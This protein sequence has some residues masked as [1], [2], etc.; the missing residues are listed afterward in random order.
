MPVFQRYNARLSYP[1]ALRSRFF[2][3]GV[4]YDPVFDRV[5]I[6]KNAEKTPDGG[7]MVDV[8][9]PPRIIRLDLGHYEVEWVPLHEPGFSPAVSPEQ[10]GPGSPDQNPES[11]TAITA[12]SLYYDKWFYRPVPGAA[13]VC[14]LGLQF[15]LYPD[16]LF[17]DQDYGA[18]RYELKQD[19]KIIVRGEN[20]DVRL[21]IIPFP[22]YRDTR[23]PIVDYLLPI[24][25]M[26]VR[27]VDDQN[28]EIF[29]WQTIVFT[30]KE[31]IYPTE[32]LACHRRGLYYI[33][34]R[35]TLPNAQQI[36]FRKIA[37]QIED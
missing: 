15:Y 6:W 36:M 34:A 26:D 7:V 37:L 29:P 18:Y 31:G 12:N 11:L 23:T 32:A 25:S 9:M 28:C 30:G 4:L 21:R 14:S 2:N 1:V 22:L 27:I 5:E 19:R 13:E 8:I 17:V 20:L 3:G 24:S 35:L 16:F 10:E 33:Q